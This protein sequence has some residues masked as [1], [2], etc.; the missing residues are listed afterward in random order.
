V[1]VREEGGEWKV[2]PKL[3]EAAREKLETHPESPPG[4]CVRE[5]LKEES[6]GLLN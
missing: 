3:D 5:F 6:S 2:I 4:D 1:E